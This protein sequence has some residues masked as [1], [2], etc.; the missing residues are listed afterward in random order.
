MIAIWGK[1][2]TLK[3]CR[4]FLPLSF[5]LLSSISIISI[6]SVLEAQINPYIQQDHAD[7][8]LI[9]S[10]LC[11]LVHLGPRRAPGIIGSSIADFG[12]CIWVSLCIILGYPQR[13]LAKVLHGV[14]VTVGCR[15]AWRCTRRNFGTWYAMNLCLKYCARPSLTRTIINKNFPH[16]DMVVYNVGDTSSKNNPGLPGSNNPSQLISP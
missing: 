9:I 2:S 15:L 10:Q 13:C 14:R 1:K 3:T 4:Q 7:T 12:L 6:K 8:Q 16:K 11:N 5:N